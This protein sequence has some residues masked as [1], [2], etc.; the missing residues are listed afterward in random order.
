MVR[1]ED[2][3][4]FKRLSQRRF[5]E[6][7]ISNDRVME[8]FARL[9]AL[10]S[11]LHGKGVV[12]GD[13]NDANVMFTH[14]EPWLIDADSMQFGHHLCTV[15]HDRFLDPVLFG[16]DFNASP[17]FSPQ[18]D[19][20]AFAVLLFQ[21]LLY[22]HPYGGVHANL[23]T[24]MRR[25]EARHSIL[26]SDVT[27]PK[28][29]AN[30]RALSDELLAYFEAVFDGRLRDTFPLRLLHTKWTRCTACGTEHARAA[31]PDC[32]SKG[33]IVVRPPT[34]H[35]GHCRAVSIVRTTGRIL[36]AT[37][38]DGLQYVI[39]DDGV[40]RR[41]NGKKVMTQP[42]Q[43]GMRFAISSSATWVGF[44]GQL[45]SIV[46]QAP[47]ARLQTGRLGTATVFDANAAGCTYVDGDWLIDQK[48]GTRIGSILEGQ[49]WVRTGR[50]VGYV[51]YRAGNVSVHSL[52]TPGR[53]GLRN[54]DLP[55][56]NGR[57]IDLDVVFDDHHALI[58]WATENLGQVQVELHMLRRDG[59]R[60]ASLAGPADSSPLLGS[61]RGKAL[62]GGRV[63]VATDA[64][65]ASVSIDTRTNTLAVQNVFVDTEP[66]VATGAQVLPGPGGSVYIVTTREITQLSV[67]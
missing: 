14:D 28:A 7:V 42:V 57:L 64:G 21:S 39:E 6:G 35:N 3:E 15:A 59:T 43:P 51:L 1:V 37:M 19:W 46:D 5:R 41:E 63:V 56:V 2:A 50:S 60:I 16:V 24:L 48:S 32:A 45:I 38:Q 47:A 65:L 62:L 17:A 36:Y 25:A 20:Y 49:T 55:P 29:A 61:T 9:H 58:T 4:D 23:C 12:V 26:R 54:V 27:I 30:W 18:T 66:F 44:R 52:F 53:A 10:L 8:I 13:L 31:C 40:T 67:A 33:A 34:R 11:D 22:V